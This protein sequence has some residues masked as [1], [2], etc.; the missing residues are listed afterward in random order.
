MTHV[1]LRHEGSVST[2]TIARSDKM[3]ALDAELLEGIRDAVHELGGRTETRCAIVTGEGKAFVAG[4]DIASMKKMSS[5]QAREFAALGHATFDAIETLPFPVIAAVNGFALGGGCELVLA[6]DFAYASDKAK[7]GQPETKL[8]I[9]PGFGGTHRLARRVGLGRA[10]EIIYTGEMI[11]A[12]EAARM[13][14]VNRVVGADDLESEVR[15]TA[16][17][18]AA[19]GP[20]AVA[21]AKRALREGADRRADDAKADEIATFA[22]CFESEEPREGMDAFVSKRTPTFGE[23]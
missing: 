17:G 9:I 21:A 19:N 22:G 15:K 23:R 10:R 4:A 20:R 16:D 13:G 7:L 18:I 14:L 3:N 2:L 12:D 5:G 8:G 1:R 11:S 6:C